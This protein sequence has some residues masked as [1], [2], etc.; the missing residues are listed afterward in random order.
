VK[1][2]SYDSIEK[3]EC[4]TEIRGANSDTVRDFKLTWDPYVDEKIVREKDRDFNYRCFEWDRLIRLSLDFGF[5]YT[6]FAAYTGTRLDGLLTL[7]NQNNDRMYLDFFASAPW[8]YFGTAG[9]MRRIGSGLVI[10][11]IKTSV[12]AGLGGEFSL[13]AIEDAEKYCE[14]I[15][16][17]PTGQFKYGLR[18]YHM[19]KEKA[20]VFEEGFRKFIINE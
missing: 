3:S 9:R 20:A 15:G 2:I 5:D 6:C 14:R 18:E 4:E 8:N 19:S 12:S 7:R 17:I 16:M 11:T 13:Y 1:F 10:F